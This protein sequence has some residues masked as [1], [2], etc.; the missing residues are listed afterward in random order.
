MVAPVPLELRRR[1]L[2]RSKDPSRRLVRI[3][4]ELRAQVRFARL[5]LMDARIRS[6]ATWT[7]SSAAT[8]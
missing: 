2:L 3:V 5:N 1:Y 8:S 6:T 4:P 7:S